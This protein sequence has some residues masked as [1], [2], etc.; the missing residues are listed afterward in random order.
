[1]DAATQITVG[2]LLMAGAGLWF[3]FGWPWA[4]AGVVACSAFLLAR[5][6]RPDQS[7]FVLTAIPLLA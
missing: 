4:V 3:R 1:V 5:R 7:L 6:R 2:G